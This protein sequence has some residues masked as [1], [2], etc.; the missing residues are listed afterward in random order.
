MVEITPST[1]ITP[2]HTPQ[3]NNSDDDMTLAESTA[4]IQAPSIGASTAVEEDT[5]AGSSHESKSR[6]RWFR[7]SSQAASQK[8]A[9][10]TGS[11]I[12]SSLKSYPDED[13]VYRPFQPSLQRED[14]W[15][16]GEDASMQLS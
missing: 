6:K 12:S 13:D 4:T 15:G 8:S 11:S 2:S 3:V 5:D 10:G 14:S 7:R 1:E 16:L 9:A